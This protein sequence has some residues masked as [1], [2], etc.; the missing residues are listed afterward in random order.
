MTNRFLLAAVAAVM[1]TVGGAAQAQAQAQAQAR[2]ADWNPAFFEK[3][4]IRCQT[5]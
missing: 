5:S 4:W 3:E 1:T 2:R